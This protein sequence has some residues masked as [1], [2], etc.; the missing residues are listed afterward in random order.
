MG[1]E[2]L[3]RKKEEGAKARVQG[4]NVV[5]EE[6]IWMKAGVVG[7]RLCDNAY[8]CHNCPFDRGMKKAMNASPEAD[9]VRDQPE[10]VD[11]MRSS[12]DGASRACRHALTGRVQAPKICAM[13]Y[14]CFHCSY[15]QML[16][17]LDLTLQTRAPHYQ[18]ASG[19]R[20][21]D[22]YYYH[23]GHSWARFE[24]GGRV[25]IGFDDFLV[26]V[27]GEPQRIEL[28]FLGATLVQNQ[29]GWSFCRD[30]H[31]AAV[32]SPVSGDVLAVNHKALDHPEISHV[33]PYQEGWLLMVEPRMPKR[34]LKGLYFGREGIRWM[35]EETKQLMGVLGPEYEQLAATGGEPVDDFYGRFPEVGWDRLA[36]TFLRTEKR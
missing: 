22:G 30:D 24:H 18:L 12:Y 1:K 9:A 33:D 4:F 16:D 17:E 29:V 5:E 14:E 3:S 10:W 6:C 28:P 35:E 36:R 15:D 19:Y 8:D 32:L 20:L 25:R 27:F 31:Q 21:A 13:N 34:D 7:F 2:K 23:L 11:H 26:K